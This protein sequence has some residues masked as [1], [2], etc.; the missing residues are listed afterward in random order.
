MKLPVSCTS[1]GE[2][3]SRL[4]SYAAR[5]LSAQRAMFQ[6]QPAA[7]TRGKPGDRNDV[8]APSGAVGRSCVFAVR[9]EGSLVVV[10]STSG[11][12]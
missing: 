5:K 11:N 9:S 2:P 1:R 3:V 8:N 12:R 10:T 6:I 7:K 4:A